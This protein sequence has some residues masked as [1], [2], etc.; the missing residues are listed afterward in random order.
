[1]LSYVVGNVVAVLI[2][3]CF[4]MFSEETDIM[5][6]LASALPATGAEDVAQG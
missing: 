1:M 5:L 3:K 4:R 2:P 6:F